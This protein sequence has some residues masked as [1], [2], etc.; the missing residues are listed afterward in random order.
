MDEDEDVEDPC[1]TV[2]LAAHAKNSVKAI[3]KDKCRGGD[4]VVNS[5]T[6]QYKHLWLSCESVEKWRGKL[7]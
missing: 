5:N 6:A 4:E 7:R 2:S 3:D 1:P